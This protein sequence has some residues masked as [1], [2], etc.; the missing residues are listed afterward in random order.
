[1]PAEDD[2]TKARLT[3]QQPKHF[4]ESSYLLLYYS[5]YRTLDP[6]TEYNTA[7][8]VPPMAFLVVRNRDPFLFQ[9]LV[10]LL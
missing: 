5:T 8:N 3:Q 1:M 2:K 6:R 4:V 7:A 10:I 9:Q